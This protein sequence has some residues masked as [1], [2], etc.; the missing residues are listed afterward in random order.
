[1]ARE[2]EGETEQGQTMGQDGQPL[3]G[4]LLTGI[5]K[6]PTT[7]YDVVQSSEHQRDLGKTES[8]TH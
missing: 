2:L 6:N 1:M 7:K 3:W 4:W 5:S 8:E